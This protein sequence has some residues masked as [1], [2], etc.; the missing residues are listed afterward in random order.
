MRVRAFAAS[1]LGSSCLLIAPTPAVARESAPADAAII[2]IV[3]RQQTLI[4]QQGK[5]L[6]EQ[7]VELEALRTRVVAISAAP[8]SI[9]TPR[10]EVASLMA[11]NEPRP[12]TAVPA[13][14]GEKTKV[15]FGG[16]V[17]LDMLYFPNARPGESEDLLYPRIFSVDPTAV[18]RGRFRASARDTR[19]NVEIKTPTS[20]GSFRAF[21][22]FDFFGSV[23]NNAQ[24]QLNSYDPRLRHAYVEWTSTSDKIAVLAGQHWSLF[25]NPVSY[26]TVYNP[27]P[28]G[29]V[30]VRQ[31]QLRVSYN[32][33]PG[34][35]LAVSAENPQGD[36]AGAGGAGINE[37]FDK[38]PDLVAAARIERR[39]GALQIGGVLREIDETQPAGSAVAWGVSGSG[40]I[41]LP[42]FD[43]TQKLRFQGTYGTGV[44]RYI[45]ELGAGFDGHISP[46][47]RL[48]TEPVFAG[49]V[50]YEH[51]FAPWLSGT[52][53]GSYVSVENPVGVAPNSIE[54]VK[55]FATNI[56]VH[57]VTALDMALEY[58]TATRGNVDGTNATRDIMR[59]STRYRF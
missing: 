54:T 30:F 38:L 32:V 29:S 4:E 37:Q 36:V 43:G 7:R 16:W 45:G 18:G 22:E 10:A 49:N 3:R 1:L 40:M 34:V 21:T 42:L 17:Q 47:Q 51:V 13:S 25:A 41:K 39:W 8:H 12:A 6:R 27:L 53:Q 23:V 46:G 2:D 35:T 24:S 20:V 31:A 15:K 57:P 26:A 19:F 48:K 50:S 9:Q 52:I 28:L 14:D 11:A 59:F 33:A 56:V 58:I 5:E 44:G 55:A